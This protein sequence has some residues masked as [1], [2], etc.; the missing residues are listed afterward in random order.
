MSHILRTTGIPRLKRFPI[1]RFHLARIFEG[2]KKNLHSA[3]TA[4]DKFKKHQIFFSGFF[5]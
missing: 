2:V 4:L 5:I 3:H 1:A